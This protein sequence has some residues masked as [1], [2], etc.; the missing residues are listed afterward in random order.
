MWNRYMFA[1]KSIR[2]LSDIHSVSV[3]PNQDLVIVG[4]H[5]ILI[6]TL[7]GNVIYNHTYTNGLLRAVTVDREGRLILAER[8]AR[9]ID[10]NIIVLLKDGTKVTSFPV[11]FNPMS[12]ISLVVDHDNCIWISD[13]HTVQVFGFL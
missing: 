8:A 10:R 7:N 13:E 9:L 12:Q 6:T 3:M 2:E 4:N 1:D 11:E 5:Q